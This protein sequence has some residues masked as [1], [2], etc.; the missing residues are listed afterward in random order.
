MEGKK[1][2]NILMICGVIDNFSIPGF[3][4]II[5]DLI[6]LGHKVTCYVLEN[7]EERLKKTGAKLKPYKIDKIDLKD[8]PP[9]MAEKIM[10]TLRIS[11]CYV[12]IIKDGLKSEEKYDFL[13]VD[14]FFDGIEL[15]KIFKI[16]NVISLY[17]CPLGEKSP[18]IQI[19][20]Q[21]RTEPFIP[22]NQQYNLNL[23]DYLILHFDANGKYKLMLTSKLFNPESILSDNSFYFI[24]PYDEEE[25]PDDPSFNFKKD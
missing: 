18:F 15:N 23:R 3:I 16:P 21:K 17:S 10:V 2:K 9:L 7:F 12:E 8:L 24:G 14:S 22:I 19:T 11:K 6:S 5:K 20:S 4:G 1:P 13:I 25:K